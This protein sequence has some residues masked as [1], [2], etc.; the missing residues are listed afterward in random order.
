MNREE[1]R[2][3]ARLG[4][5]TLELAMAEYIRN[6]ATPPNNADVSNALGLG[7]GIAEAILTGNEVMF[8]DTRKGGGMHKWQVR[9]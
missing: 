4:V 2:R 8:R 9:E 7:D 3:L 1:Q 6:R 5:E